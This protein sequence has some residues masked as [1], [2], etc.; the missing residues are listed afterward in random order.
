[1]SPAVI[2]GVLRGALDYRGVVVS[3]D[4]DMNAITSH[5]GIAD[6][7]IRAVRAGCDA[8]LLCRIEDHQRE[9]RAALIAEAERDA[10]FRARVGEAAERVRALGRQHALLSAAAEPTTRDT[11]GAAAHRALADRLTGRG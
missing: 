6:A 8:L 2:G 11:I 7:A 10:A 5:W 4:L 1:L 9:A 3:D